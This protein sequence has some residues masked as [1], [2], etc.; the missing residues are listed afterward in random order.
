MSTHSQQRHPIRRYGWWRTLHIWQ[1]VMVVGVLLGVLVIAVGLIYFEPGALAAPTPVP[2][3]PG[4]TTTPGSRYPPGTDEY[5]YWG[6]NQPLNQQ[7]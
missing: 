6:Q 7:P 4:G 2:T 3:A 5:W 1:R